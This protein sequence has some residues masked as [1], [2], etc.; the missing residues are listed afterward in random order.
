[1]LKQKLLARRGE[2]L[3]IVGA[4]GSGKSTLVDEILFRRLAQVFYH[5][6]DT[7]GKDSYFHKNRVGFEFGDA[8]L[9]PDGTSHLLLV[10]LAHVAQLGDQLFH[11]RPLAF[12]ERHVFDRLGQAECRRGGK[13]KDRHNDRAD[14]RR[15]PRTRYV[16]AQD[17]IPGPQ[18]R[19][20]HARPVL[21]RRRRGAGRGA[22]GRARWRPPTP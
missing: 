3:A 22:G 9:S 13:K 19:H 11:L 4:S 17:A 5:G 1:M 10:G 21:A 20:G 12:V 14:G 8:S 16:H 7:P 2:T 15:A 6:K 18:L